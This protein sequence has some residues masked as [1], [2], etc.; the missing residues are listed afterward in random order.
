MKSVMDNSSVVI[1]AQD[2]NISIF[3]PWWLLKEGIFNE[4]E[5]AGEVVVTP[6]TVQ[7]R[8]EHYEFAVLPNRVQ[9]TCPRN[10]P[11]AQKN[12]DRILG[13]VAR[14]LPHTPYSAVG[15]NFHYLA[16]PEGTYGTWNR[17]WFTGE[18]TGSVCSKDDIA[19]RFGSYFSMDTLGT[20]LKVNITPV[21]A[22][23]GIEKFC[24]DWGIGEE[25]LKF[26]FNFHVDVVSGNAAAE[27]VVETVSKWTKALEKSK[28]IVDMLSDQT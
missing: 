5:V 3:K 25:L 16:R 10:Y 14:T 24:D 1:T 7:I 8:T 12:I 17:R 4:S 2:V 19:A 28:E 26:D 27:C 6:V 15:L 20:R 22:G 11:D 9:M 18:F 21:T 23:Q 13:G